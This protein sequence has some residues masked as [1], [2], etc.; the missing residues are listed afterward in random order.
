MVIVGGASKRLGGAIV[1]RL[2]A[3]RL[4]VIGVARDVGKLSTDIVFWADINKP[5]YSEFGPL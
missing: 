1:D 2:V 4:E 3:D 5:K